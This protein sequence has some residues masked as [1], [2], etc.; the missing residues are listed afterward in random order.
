MGRELRLRAD[1][2]T[3]PPAVIAPET[4]VRRLA[5]QAVFAP[6]ALL[7]TPHRDGVELRVPGNVS[8]MPDAIVTIEE[9]GFYLLDNNT[10]LADLVLGQLVRYLLG[11]FDRVT[12]EEP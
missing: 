3:W 1:G 11:T 8:D 5:Q 12:L 2:G 9:G 6:Y 7:V 4:F 10:M